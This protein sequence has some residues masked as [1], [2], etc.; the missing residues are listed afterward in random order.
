MN[1]SVPKH[2]WQGENEAAE[3]IPYQTHVD[4][5]TI[6]TH[7]GDYLQTIRLQGVAHESVAPEQVLTLERT[8]EFVA[9]KYC[10][11]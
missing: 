5:H 3:F 8:T 9:A 6:K 4:E 1:K 10:Q 11:P 7:S 2:I